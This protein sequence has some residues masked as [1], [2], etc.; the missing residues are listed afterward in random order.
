M[1]GFG[2]LSQAKLKKNT[3]TH[4][5]THVGAK[6][7]NFN[8]WGLTVAEKDF[9]LAYWLPFFPVKLVEI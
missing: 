9:P 2:N 5:H 6:L 3:H 7:Y 4:T 8:V 1:D